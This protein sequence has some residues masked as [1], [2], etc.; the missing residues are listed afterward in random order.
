[1][2]SQQLDSSR[3][4]L[5]A[6][7]APRE[8]AAVIVEALQCD[9]GVLVPAPGFL[10][11]VREVCDEFGTLLIIDEVKAGLGRTGR[12]FAYEESEV[13]PDLVTLGKSLGGGL[14]ASAVI[15]PS[16]ALAEPKASALLTTAGA[17]IPA[18]A[19]CAVLDLLA[20]GSLVKAAQKL[21][22]VVREVIESYRLS[23]RPGAS[24][25]S[26][27][28]GRGLLFGLELSGAEPS[29]SADKGD[30]T[31]AVEFA[32]LTVYRAW[33]LG[34]VIYVVRDN[35][36]EI[37]PPLVISEVELRDGLEC[38]LTAIDDAASGR[39]PIDSIADYGGW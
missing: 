7:L 1:M 5:R 22:D 2:T 12:L 16:S 25:V 15:G 30:I 28:R 18:A 37:T 36:L 26:D 34:C 11:A 27:V 32:A 33:E 23:G 31:S 24:R 8:T 10:T 21:G 29:D 9:G 20:D 17:P 4:Q 13:F 38:I 14:P 6:L 3:R 35:V 19:A 39:V